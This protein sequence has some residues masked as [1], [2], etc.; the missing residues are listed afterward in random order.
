MFT[1]SPAKV[2]VVTNVTFSETTSIIN[3]S[4]DIALAEQLSTSGLDP[5]AD[6]ELSVSHPA[7]TKAAAD[8]NPKNFLNIIFLFAKFSP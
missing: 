7:K 4:S 6:V 1:K 5:E 3:V 2:V 8:A